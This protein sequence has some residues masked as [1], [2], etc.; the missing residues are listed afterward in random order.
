MMS[1][2]SEKLAGAL[3]GLSQLVDQL[4]EEG[5]ARAGAYEGLF[6]YGVLDRLKSHAEV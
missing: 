5:L 6:A 1:S 4:K 2:E 3:M